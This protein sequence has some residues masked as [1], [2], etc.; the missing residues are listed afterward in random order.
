MHIPEILKK[1]LLKQL[2]HDYVKIYQ[3]VIYQ[4]LTNTI[5][6]RMGHNGDELQVYK[7]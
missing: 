5:I 3:S 2:P 7:L 6:T 4:V 1:S